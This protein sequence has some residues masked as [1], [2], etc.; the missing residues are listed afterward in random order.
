MG[1]LN[2][3][4]INFTPTGEAIATRKN[5]DDAKNKTH[6]KQGRVALHQ[7]RFGYLTKVLLHEWFKFLK[8]GI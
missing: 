6:K 2:G 8:L 7:E 3:H 1:T 4:L 5:N